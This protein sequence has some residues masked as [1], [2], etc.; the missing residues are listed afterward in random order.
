MDV[1]PSSFLCEDNWS[2]EKGL[3]LVVPPLL[4]PD[5]K[6]VVSFSVTD[7]HDLVHQYTTIKG[8]RGR[9]GPNVMHFN[10]DQVQGLLVCLFITK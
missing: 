2:E 6:C 10:L 7:L 1:P 3:G 9:K 8:L 5:S 4:D